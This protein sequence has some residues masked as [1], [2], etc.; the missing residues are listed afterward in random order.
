VLDLPLPR[1][2][3]GHLEHVGAR[4]PSSAE[5]GTPPFIIR[6]PECQG[7]RLL[8]PRSGKGRRRCR[9][10]CHKLRAAG[11]VPLGLSKEA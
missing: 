2:R 11:L 9:L 7:Q 6:I 8:M 4:P 5:S 10:P 3:V 1:P